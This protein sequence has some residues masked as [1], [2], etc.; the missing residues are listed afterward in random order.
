MREGGIDV[1]PTR[2]FGAL[3]SAVQRPIAAAYYS[4]AIL[5]EQ[6]VILAT[7]ISQAQAFV[8]GNKRAAFQALD[9]FLYLNGKEFVAEPLALAD[10]LIAVA[11]A[12][13]DR[14]T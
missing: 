4:G 11:R 3:Q 8:D 5:I 12:S 9:L 2:D 13:N 1:P 10:Q 7:A 14:E 6:A